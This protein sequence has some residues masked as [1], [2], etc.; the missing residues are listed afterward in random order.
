MA[1]RSLHEAKR[2]AERLRQELKVVD[3]GIVQPQHRGDFALP[4]ARLEHLHWQVRQQRVTVSS[5]EA[6]VDA[7]RLVFVAATRKRKTLEQLKIFRANAHT[8]RAQLLEE[9]DIDESNVH[10]R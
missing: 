2:E 9:R 3:G 5:L 8:R 1:Q 6:E 4:Y 7:T 10:V